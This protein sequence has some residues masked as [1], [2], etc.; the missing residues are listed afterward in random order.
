MFFFK[1]GIMDFSAFSYKATQTHT[2][3]QII[4]GIPR[5]SLPTRNDVKVK[6]VVGKQLRMALLDPFQFL[7]SSEMALHSTML[8]TPNISFITVL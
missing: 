1:S 4:H 2:G 6:I 5:S 7:T 3:P 8:S